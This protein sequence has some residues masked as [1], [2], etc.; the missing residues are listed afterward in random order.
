MVTISG[1]LKRAPAK[2]PIS[3]VGM[4]QWTWMGLA[5]LFKQNIDCNEGSQKK[6]KDH[7]QIWNLF[8]FN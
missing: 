6:I 3:P 7:S 2:T 1:F 5:S 8:V 4:T